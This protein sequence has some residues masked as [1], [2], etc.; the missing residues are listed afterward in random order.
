LLSPT[1]LQ[2]GTIATLMLTD[3]AKRLALKGVA[4]QL[5]ESVMARLLAEGYDPQYGARPMRRAVTRLVHDTLSESLL[6]EEVTE[7]DT[8]VL[9]V[10]RDTEALEVKVLRDTDRPPRLDLLD[11]NPTIA[12]RSTEPLVF[13]SLVVDA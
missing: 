10:H 4:L 6:R 8:A 3:T 7:G 12:F 11:L 9:Y 5:T 13:S 2:V 1:A